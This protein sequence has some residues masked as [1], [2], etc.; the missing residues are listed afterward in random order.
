MIFIRLNISIRNGALT[1]QKAL[2]F[3]FLLFWQ[4][5]SIV[6]FVLPSNL[7]LHPNLNGIPLQILDVD[8]ILSAQ[9]YL[10]TNSHTEKVNELLKL[11]HQDTIGIVSVSQTDIKQRI[12]SQISLHKKTILHPCISFEITNPRSP[13]SSL[14]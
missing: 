10:I 14:S 6:C 9:N 3:G 8:D 12:Y 11:K 5:H 4:L 1:L 2:L 13:P 7:N